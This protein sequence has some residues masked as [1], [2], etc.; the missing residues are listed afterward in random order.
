M[1]GRRVWHVSAYVAGSP[2][3][4]AIGLL[5]LLRLQGAAQKYGIVYADC[6]RTVQG[7]IILCESHPGRYKLIDIR[8]RYRISVTFTDATDSTASVIATTSNGRL[9]CQR[10]H[11][12]T[13][14]ASG[15]LIINAADR[16]CR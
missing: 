5:S 12:L 4:I 16:R 10:G 14:A 8:R 13:S 11:L 1:A 9:C 3:S 2:H 7:I 15:S 6:I